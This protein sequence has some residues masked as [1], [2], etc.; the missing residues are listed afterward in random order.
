MKMTD[1]L[2]LEG[3]PFIFQNLDPCK[4]HLN[5]LFNLDYDQIND[6]QFTNARKSN[7]RKA[8]DIK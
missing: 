7:N 4:M 2:S 8:H 6:V 5:F 3:Y 1:L